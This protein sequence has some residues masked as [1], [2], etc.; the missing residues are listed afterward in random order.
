V[1]SHVKI[2]FGPALEAKCYLEAVVPPH[3]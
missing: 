1:L 3:G 2:V